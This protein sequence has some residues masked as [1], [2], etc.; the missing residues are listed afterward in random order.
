MTGGADKTGMSAELRAI[1]RELSN[2][3]HT[4][5]A[6]LSL[7][8]ERSLADEIVVCGILGGKD[9]GKSTLINALAQRCVSVD[10]S[11]VGRGT[12]R[13]MVYVHTDS[14]HAVEERLAGLTAE[15][16][17]DVTLHEVDS[18]RNVVLVDLPDFDSEFI[19]HLDVV[20]R[21]AP[22]LDRVLWVLTPRKIGDRAWVEMFRDVIKDIRNV[23]CV[24]NKVDELLADADPF[25]PLPDDREDRGDRFWRMQHEWVAGMIESTGCPHTPDHRF[26]VAAAFPDPESLLRRVDQLWDDPDAARYASDRN[27]VERVAAL[28]C[29]DLDRLRSCVLGPI[30]GEQSAALKDANR[31][32]EQHTNIDRVN[33]HYDLPHVMEQLAMATDASYHLTLIEEAWGPSYASAVTDALAPKLRSETE[34][35]D[36]LLEHRVSRWPLLRLAHW[37]FGWLSRM[38]GRRLDTTARST[39]ED[40]VADPCEVEGRSLRTR[41]ELMRSHILAD[42]AAIID[43]FDLQDAVPNGAALE[44]RAA[45][46]IEQ[47][48]AV[49]QRQLMQ[50]IVDRDRR[51]SLMA[52]GMLWLILLWFPFLQPVGEGILQIFAEDG[53]ASLTLGAYKIV[54]ALSA[55]HLLTGFAVVAGTYV[56]FLAGMYVRALRAVHEVCRSGSDVPAA[57]PLVDAVD[58]TLVDEVLLPLVA[59]LQDRLER[60]TGLR[61]RLDVASGSATPT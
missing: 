18:I 28:A 53:T 39:R 31:Q 23:Q 22:W 41:I 19:E 45:A 42:H 38:L 32:R 48:P 3:L 61:D 1:N 24:L 34:L 14:R 54:S 59:P 56:A 20:R 44:K 7:G 13:P 47:L 43:R 36:E 46:R 8:A 6:S 5:P 2:L 17:F 52:R 27:A 50:S 15:V 30:S 37:P 55:V 4:P 10:S 35:A 29:E 26:L 60:L 51:P 25:S 16:P 33:A 40:A 9:V 58:Q 49:W 11:E 57:H 12:E 21:V